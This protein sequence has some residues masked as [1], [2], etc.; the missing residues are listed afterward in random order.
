MQELQ[1]QGQSLASAREQLYWLCTPLNIATFTILVLIVTLSVKW[2]RSGSV[3]RGRFSERHTPL[4]SVEPRDSLFI[5]LVWNGK[6]ACGTAST[7]KS[8]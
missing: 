3:Q 7:R 4:A 1:R 8:N 2:K 5:G 6:R